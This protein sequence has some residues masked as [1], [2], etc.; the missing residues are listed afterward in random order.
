M[1]VLAELLGQL[2][3]NLRCVVMNACFSAHQAEEIA[4]HVDCVIGVS[5]ELTD[6]VAL[7]FAETFYG[8]LAQGE[9]VR[10]AFDV[11]RI[12]LA[13]DGLPQ[14]EAF[15]LETRDQVDANEVVLGLSLET[16]D[17]ADANEV[18]LE[19]ACEPDSGVGLPRESKRFDLAAATVGLLAMAAM[20]A[21]GVMLVWSLGE[22]DPWNTAVEIKPPDQECVDID[23]GVSDRD[24]TPAPSAGVKAKSGKQ[25]GTHGPRNLKLTCV[26]ALSAISDEKGIGEPPPVF[27]AVLSDVEPRI[28][29]EQ[30]GLTNTDSC[31]R[32]VITA[33]NVKDYR[34]STQNLAMVVLI[35][36]QS[37]WMG[38]ETYADE[39]EGSE[40][41]TGAFTG[42]AP[43]IEALRAAGPPGSQ[44]ALLVYARGKA[45]EKQPMGDA[46]KLSGAW[47]GSQKDYEDTLDTPLI[48]GI[49]TAAS[50]L[51]EYDRHRRALVVIGDG[52]GEREVISDEIKDAVRK[53]KRRKIE[54]Y[55][56]F[57]NS[58]FDKALS[59]SPEPEGQL[60]MKELGYTGSYIAS[61]KESFAS[62]A[63][64]IVTEIGNRYYVTFSACAN[65]D[66]PRCL[67]T[68]GLLHEFVL[69]IDNEEQAIAKIKTCE[70][71]PPEAENKERGLSWL[72]LLLVPFIVVAGV[73]W[74]L[75]RS[76]AESTDH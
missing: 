49:E 16:R 27:E 59:S 5:A 65:T 32:L 13:I 29:G 45:V 63:G 23:A 42:L 37:A 11:A 72:L 12:D 6:P 8:T 26:D 17:Q 34:T 40:P 15:S 14:G 56:I 25:P 4:A 76:R 47:L 51:D 64:D 10:K 55:T 28:A 41:W 43:A 73:I 52:T 60:V 7:T 46:S 33:T 61:S 18:V 67:P 74:A 22:Q 2:N 20:L 54:V 50:L 35:Q 66:P 70:W 53:L 62:K 75:I 71:G 39:D 19:P 30:F 68:D 24:G 38:N 57:Y 1:S 3:D 31:P 48:T 69:L 36:G 58:F 21:S 9:S 44:A